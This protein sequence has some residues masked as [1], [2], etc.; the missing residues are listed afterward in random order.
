MD[1]KAKGLLIIVTFLGFVAVTF[2]YRLPSEVV[3]VKFRGEVDL[4]PFNCTAV[5]A[6]S[7]VKRVC[8]DS[9]NQYM[10]INLNGTY[11]TTARS[12]V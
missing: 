12:I 3:Q 6:S 8:Y 4:R 2:A 10:L 1:P 11:S 5:S 9:S 7:L